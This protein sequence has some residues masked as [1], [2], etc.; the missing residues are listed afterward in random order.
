MLILLNFLCLKLTGKNCH[1]KK[2]I[3]DLLK[4]SFVLKTFWLIYLYILYQIFLMSRVTI[5]PRVT[6]DYL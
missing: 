6:Y 5:R 4:A 2:K 3:M 1:P